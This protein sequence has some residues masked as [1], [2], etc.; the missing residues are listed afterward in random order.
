M[1]G[2]LKS[3]SGGMAKYPKVTAAAKSDLN[4]VPEGEVNR[5]CRNMMLTIVLLSTGNIP[6]I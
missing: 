3:L 2:S 6:K 5:I 1:E 4:T